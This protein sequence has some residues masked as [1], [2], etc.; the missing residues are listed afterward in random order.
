MKEGPVSLMMHDQ[1]E[2]GENSEDQQ[3]LFVL[4]KFFIGTQEH[5]VQPVRKGWVR[6]RENKYKHK[7]DH[8]T[9]LGAADDGVQLW[10][11]VLLVI[12]GDGAGTLTDAFMFL[13]F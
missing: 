12:R 13:I 2:T 8:G 10:L 11:T 7:Q 9:H 1:T 5:T 3:V 6:I 4:R